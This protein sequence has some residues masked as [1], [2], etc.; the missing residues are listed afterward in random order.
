MICVKSTSLTSVKGNKYIEYN[1]LEDYI[2]LGKS[3]IFYNHR[4]RKP[5]EEFMMIL[6]VKKIT[7]FI[8]HC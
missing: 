2:N 1:G 5:E 4:E 3:I 8:I 6:I 7:K